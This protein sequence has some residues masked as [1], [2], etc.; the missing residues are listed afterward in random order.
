MSVW[1]LATPFTL[2]L[3]MTDRLAMRTSPS[4][5]TAVFRRR[6][7]QSGISGVNWSRQRREISSMIW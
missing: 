7:C 5:S 3:Q 4:Q 1:I 2:W 6:S